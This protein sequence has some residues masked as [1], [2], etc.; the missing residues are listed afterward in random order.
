ME[1]LN[2]IIDLFLLF[3]IYS[4]IGWMIEVTFVSISSKKFINRGF[5]IGPYCP[6]YGCGGLAISLL[7]KN[8]TSDY[9]VTFVLSSVIASVI[10]YITSFLNYSK[11]DG[12]T[13]LKRNLILT[14]EFVL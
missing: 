9:V 2:Y 3:L 1:V 5:L 13:I 10:E 14:E 7:L 11:L 4:I 8:Y 6:I 12:G